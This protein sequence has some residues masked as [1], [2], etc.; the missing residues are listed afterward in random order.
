[1]TIKEQIIAKAVELLL[2]HP[3]G[4]RYSELLARIQRDLPQVPKNTIGGTIWNL[5]V[6]LPAQVYKPARGMYIH[7]QYRESETAP[8]P[9]PAPPTVE[10]VKEERFYEPFA[11]WLV[12]ELEEC[13]KAISVGGNA[14]KDKWGTPDVIGVREPKK[15]DIIKFPTEIVSAEVKIDTG[16]LITAFGQACAYRLFS[17]KSYIVVPVESPEDD[18]GRLDTLARIFGIGLI[19]FDAKDP[20]NPKFEIRVRAAKHEPDM[21]YVN[22]CMKFIEDDLFS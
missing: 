15:S 6:Q 22:R 3:H 4:F 20:K 18:I 10:K 21:F 19:L 12:K 7:T 5:E 11:D 2:K 9:I 1:M 16:G 17:H 13:T 8:A 14:F